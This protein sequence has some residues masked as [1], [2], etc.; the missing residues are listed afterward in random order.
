MIPTARGLAARHGQ[1]PHHGARVDA[2]QPRFNSP[3]VG[4][5]LVMSIAA[6][7]APAHPGHPQ[8]ERD[9]PGRR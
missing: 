5:V 6:A 2:G 7:V 3:A 8:A 1:G 9:D 4:T